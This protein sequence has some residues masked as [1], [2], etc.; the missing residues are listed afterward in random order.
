[1]SREQLLLT[2]K[3][4]LG[5]AGVAGDR[6]ALLCDIWEHVTDDT[7]RLVYADWL[8]EHGAGGLDAATAEFIRASCLKGTK[9]GCAMPRT[10]YPWI[11][12]NWKRLI[13][14]AVAKYDV[15]MPRDHPD[16][17]RSRLRHMGFNGREVWTAWYLEDHWTRG[18]SVNLTYYR[19]FVTAVGMWSA[20]SRLELYP[21]LGQDQ[22]LFLRKPDQPTGRRHPRSRRPGPVLEG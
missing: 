12:A 15:L 11:R 16:F 13:P 6:L 20:V 17:G 8:D 2:V 9:P 3:S 10:A 21:L 5:K 4:R 14:T 7:P 18:A 22:P 1:M 19:G